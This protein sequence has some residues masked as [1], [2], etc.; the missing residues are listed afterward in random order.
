MRRKKSEE[1]FLITDEKPRG[2]DILTGVVKFHD[3]RTGTQEILSR[4][5]LFDSASS[6]EFGE[7][8][9]PSST[10]GSPASRRRRRRKKKAQSDIRSTE[11]DLIDISPQMG[12][13]K[14]KKKRTKKRERTSKSPSRLPEMR[15]PRITI[16]ETSSEEEIEDEYLCKVNIFPSYLKIGCEN[17]VDYAFCLP[18]N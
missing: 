16:E 9:S 18:I 5:N 3:P 17:S 7:L 6:E 10:P 8:L 13:K 1:E 4:A 15:T 14:S 12:K 2:E 11:G